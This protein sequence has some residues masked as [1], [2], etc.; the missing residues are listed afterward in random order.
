M[1]YGASLRQLVTYSRSEL[2][3]IIKRIRIKDGFCMN[4][5]YEPL[6]HAL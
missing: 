5:Y 3:A 4:L 1:K 2:P 6:L